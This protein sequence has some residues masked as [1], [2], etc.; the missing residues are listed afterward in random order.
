MHVHVDHWLRLE[1][2]RKMEQTTV[3]NFLFFL[4]WGLGV[5]SKVVVRRGGLRRRR[6]AT[7]STL[8]AVAQSNPA[9]P[10]FCPH[11]HQWNCN[12]VGVTHS[13]HH[14][15][16]PHL[17]FPHMRLYAGLFQR[18][19]LEMIVKILFE[20]LSYSHQL[21]HPDPVPVFR[22]LPGQVCHLGSD[23]VDGRLLSFSFLLSYLSV[24]L[25]ANT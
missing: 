4:F 16:K 20:S 19:T 3:S 5:G 15:A 17:C 22:L 21:G 13:N 18:E 2:L 1:G 12:P 7:P 9:Y 11:V 8:E 24:M 10:T 14:Q 23:S 25:P 6:E